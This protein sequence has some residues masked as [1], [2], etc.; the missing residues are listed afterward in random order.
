MIN[1]PENMSGEEPLRLQMIVKRNKANLQEAQFGIFINN[2][3]DVTV[4][5]CYTK[6]VQLPKEGDLFTVDVVIP[7]HSLAKGMYKIDMN[8][9]RFDYKALARDYDLIFGALSFEVK[10][11]D[12]LHQE[13]FT[14]WPR[15]LGSVCMQDVDVSIASC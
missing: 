6:A 2:T 12:A 3:S 1:D 14:A 9:S 7:H 15:N 11:V 13:L 4:S 8:I 10:Y 5:A